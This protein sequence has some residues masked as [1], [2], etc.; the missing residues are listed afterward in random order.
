MKKF[1]QVKI[2][3]IVVVWYKDLLIDLERKN[4]ISDSIGDSYNIIIIISYNIDQDI[5][6]DTYFFN[7]TKRFLDEM[8]IF[9][10]VHEFLQFD[11]KVIFSITICMGK[12]HNRIDQYHNRKWEENQ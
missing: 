9:K 7:K 10:D 8:L 12:N 5:L 6:I 11:V 1:L 4:V 2:C 3:S